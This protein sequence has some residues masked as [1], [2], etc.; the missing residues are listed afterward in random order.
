MEG[1]AEECQVCV[2]S[3]RVVPESC[4]RRDGNSVHPGESPRLSCAHLPGNHCLNAT[5]ATLCP[6]VSWNHLSAGP[7]PCLHNLRNLHRDLSA[8]D[9]ICTVP[10]EI[11]ALLGHNS[12]LP[13]G[14]RE[15]SSASFKLVLHI[16]G[17]FL[18]AFNNF[19]PQMTHALRR[20]LPT[21]S[22]L[23]HKRF[24]LPS[25]PLVWMHN[26]ERVLLST[27]QCECFSGGVRCLHLKG[28][29]VDWPWREF[30]EVYHLLRVLILL[31]VHHSPLP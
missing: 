7:Y 29:L 16:L 11:P 5:F 25:T 9:L 30:A 12:T 26:V 18:K 10:V 21:S 27:L 4:S 15:C 23:T 17:S 14:E 20:L 2:F 3:F 24:A 13:G 19:S 22:M 1:K 6:Q 31:N 8:L 28:G